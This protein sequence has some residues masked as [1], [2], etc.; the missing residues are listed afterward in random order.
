MK[1]KFGGH[2]LIDLMGQQFGLLRV[3]RRGPNL[4]LTRKPERGRKTPQIAVTWLCH[5]AC[6]TDK[7]IRASSL[8]RGTQSC[9]CASAELMSQTKTLDLTGKRFGKLL[10][11]RHLPN[12]RSHT[13]QW[14][15]ECDC[16]NHVVTR[17]ANL[18]QYQRS[19]GCTSRLPAGE[20]CKRFLLRQYKFQARA[21]GLTF[22]I[23]DIEAFALFNSNCYYCDTPPSRV[24]VHPEFN[25]R[26]IA[27][28]IDRADNSK[29]YVP[30]N[31]VACCGTCNLAKRELTVDEF[32]SW[33]RRL[34]AFQGRKQ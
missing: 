9:G 28:G 14:L 25:G 2:N 24:I 30:G 13:Q 21:R 31:C 18:T 12:G 15:C 11:L 7:L 16:G 1:S 10:I 33:A 3:V 5:C 27:S 34:T 6:G 32:L 4:T 17:T 29:G 26:F 19:C 8:R 23:T 22:S 20:A